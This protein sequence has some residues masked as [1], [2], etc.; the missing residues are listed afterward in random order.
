LFSSGENDGCFDIRVW[1]SFD[2]VQFI[3]IK[4]LGAI[5]DWFVVDYELVTGDF[6]NEFSRLEL[7]LR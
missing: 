2:N 6:D 4:N 3:Y 7:S 5:V 1:Y